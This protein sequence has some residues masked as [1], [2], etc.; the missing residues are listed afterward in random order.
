M[1]KNTLV[2]NPSAAPVSLTA[3]IS[4]S[5]YEIQVSNGSYT[6][7]FFTASAIGGVA[8]YTYE[9]SISRG[10]VN[11][12]QAIKTNCTLTGFYE[13]A[14]A[15]LTLTVTDDNADTTTTQTSLLITFGTP[16]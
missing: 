6:T 5:N 1:I 7:P 14:S 13:G 10:A 16:R 4:A 15:I 9:W 3:F 12:P 11:Q 8:P 2:N